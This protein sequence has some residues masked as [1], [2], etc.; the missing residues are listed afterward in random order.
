MIN[1]LQNL[2][3]NPVTMMKVFRGGTC[4]FAVLAVILWALEQS[5]SLGHALIATTV[6]LAGW[7][8]NSHLVE[9]MSKKTAGATT[10]DTTSTEAEKL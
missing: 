5:A 7:A 8:F 4:A 1:A 6:C 3:S 2:L 10:S 9:R